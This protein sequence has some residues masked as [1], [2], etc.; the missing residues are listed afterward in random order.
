[1][2]PDF[3][4]GLLALVFEPN[5][6]DA[7]GDHADPGAE[8]AAAAPVAPDRGAGGRR[9]RTTTPRC[10]ST[11]ATACC[12]T[13]RTQQRRPSRRAGRRRHEVPLLRP[14]PPRG[15]ASAAASANA[16]RVPRGAATAPRRPACRASGR[17]S[18]AC[19]GP[20]SRSTPDNLRI[21]GGERIRD[22]RHRVV[23]AGRR[24]A[25]AGRRRPGRRR[26]RPAAHAGGP[27]RQRR[28]LLALHA[29]HRR[30]LR[31]RRAAG[32]LRSAAV[33]DRVLV[34]GRM[35]VGLRLRRGR[36]VPAGRRA[37]SPTS[38]TW[39][40]TITGFRR[41]MLD[42]LSLLAPGWTER[43][44]ADLGVALVE[45][46]AYAAD[47][48]SYRQ[49]AIA[50]EAYLATARQ[51][52]SVRRHARLVDYCLHEGCNARA[53]VHVEV[54]GQDVALPHGTPAADAHAPGCQPVVAPGSRALRDA[55]AGRR[56]GVRDRARRRARRAPQP[57]VA[58]T[59]GAT[60]AAA[61]R[62]A[63][64]RATLRG[65]HRTRC[66]V[67]DVLVFEE[68]VSPTTFVAE[69]ADRTAPLGGAAD[70]GAADRAIR[71][72]GCS[73]SR[74]ST[75]RVDVTEIAWD[76]ADALPFPLCLS[77]AGAAG[78]RD[79]RRAAAT[80]C[81]PTTAGP[82]PTRR[83]ARVPRAT[84]AARRRR[85]RGG[86]CDKPERRAGAAALP[87]GARASAPLTHG[88]D[89]ARAARR[90]DRRRRGLVAGQLA[91]GAST[92]ATR[93]PLIA[94]LTG[95]LGARRRGLD[96]RGATCSSSARRRRRLRRRD[97][98][99]RPRARCAS[100][101]TSTASGPIPAPRFAATYRVGNGAAGNVGAE[102]IA[103]VVSRADG[104]FDRACATRCRPP[105]A[106]SPEDIEAVRRDA[107]EAFRT[108]ERAVTAGRLR[109]GGR[110]AARGA[111]RGGHLPLDRQLAHRVRHA[112][113]LRR[114]RG[115]RAVR[116]AA[117]PPSRA[118]PHGRLRPRGRRAALSCRSTS[119]CTSACRPTTSAPTCCGPCATVLSSGV[120][121]D[122]PLGLFHPDNFSFG[123]PVYLSRIDR[124]RAGGRGRRGGAAPTAS[125][126]WSTRARRRSTTAS[127]PSAARDRAARQQPELSASAAGST[128][129]GRRRQMSDAGARPEAACAAARAGQRSCGCCD[130]IEA[131][132]PQGIVNRGGL[133]AI[134]YR[135]GDYAQFRASLHAALSSLAL[136]GAAARC[137]RA[138]TTTSRSA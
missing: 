46:L 64:T 77:V 92:R 93:T 11:C 63:A 107:P 123:E 32:R 121:P 60:T 44:A 72:A 58:S 87:A 111:A 91:A 73:T 136:R 134:A 103:H 24:A 112:R 108:Q 34:Q 82:S 101:T 48:L 129:D 49:D 2:R 9:S 62:A 78:P 128:L 74:R 99:R 113:P 126:G 35:P 4:G 75:G 23:R 67:G 117:A 130:G 109:R 12:A 43:S 80:S 15:A 55:L 29:A 89:L 18:C 71:R 106:S 45:L 51:R 127:S 14:A 10:G 50:N 86:C 69:D 17:C 135:I 61:C 27:H 56:A 65:H 98:G 22:G 39:P 95:T 36:A 19:C 138:T 53:F 110:A 116:G 33:V 97:R 133:S 25:A 105:A 68:V 94:A 104:V 124:R 90:A 16:H 79:Q 54:V 96:A 1:M 115:R 81:S 59:P 20:A 6:S 28:R 76:A 47:N 52:V 100:A 3:G 30:E 8:R 70:R 42:R 5:S 37:P 88:F 132:T 84:A 125:S 122:G 83:S 13:A 7:R 114:R 66:S 102:A 131:E 31:Q 119:R 137:A 120:L 118:L 41:L 85:R 21:D 40:R 57:A 26:R 38:T